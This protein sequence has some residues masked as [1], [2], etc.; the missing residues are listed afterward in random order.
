M[1]GKLKEASFLKRIL[2]GGVAHSH[3]VCHQDPIDK[4][5]G[6]EE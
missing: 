5:T 6:N 4:T 3:L 2:L 1:D